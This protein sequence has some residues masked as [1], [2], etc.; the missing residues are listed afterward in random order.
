MLINYGEFNGKLATVIDAVDSKRVLVDGPQ[1]ITGVHRHVIGLKR[2][3]LTDVVVKGIKR[4][5]TAKS[6]E[7]AWKAENTL[8]TWSKSAWAQKIDKKN[9][10][11]ELGDFDR[12]KVMLAKKERSK[13]VKK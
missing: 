13:L 12:F 6:L 5:A 7:K 11:K 9:K 2:I 1:D 10:R 8:E 4:N 3:S